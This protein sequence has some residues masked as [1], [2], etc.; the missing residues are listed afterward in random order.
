MLPKAVKSQ[1]T[2]AGIPGSIYADIIPDTLLNAMPSQGSTSFSYY[3]DMDQ[4]GADD[5]KIT[6]S[7][8]G[9]LGGY[10][11]ATSVTSLDTSSAKF[12]FLR[13]DSVYYLPNCGGGSAPFANILKPYIAGDTIANDIYINSGYLSRAAYVSNCYSFSEGIWIKSYDQFI[14]VKHI[15]VQGIRYGWIRI[16][17]SGNYT[18]LVKD[19]SLGIPAVGVSVYNLPAFGLFPNPAS[20]KISIKAQDY[21]EAI[22][23]DCSGI[24]VLT[25]SKSEIDVSAL[26]PGMYLVR[27]KSSMGSCTKK[28]L[29]QR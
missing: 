15:S 24:A 11:Y 9:G 2:I 19:F 21:R 29:I 16:V 18:V 12:S 4:D 13:T 22:F 20:N 17:V 5:I 28:I 25:A 27:V 6:A 26:T 10:D 14:G 3:V 1:Y 7:S 8:A 23:Y